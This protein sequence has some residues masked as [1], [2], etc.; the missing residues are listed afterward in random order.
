[1]MTNQDRWLQYKHLSPAVIIEAIKDFANVAQIEC[2]CPENHRECDQQIILTQYNRLVYA[3]KDTELY[4]Y[5]TEYLDLLLKTAVRCQKT[6]DVRYCGDNNISEFNLY[7]PY[8][9]DMDNGDPIAYIQV[10]QLKVEPDIA[11]VVV[12]ARFAKAPEGDCCEP[13]NSAKEAS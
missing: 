9:N 3:S 12:S 5:V 4:D 10:H 8:P 1:M 7:K 6:F 11:V 13:N 2:Y